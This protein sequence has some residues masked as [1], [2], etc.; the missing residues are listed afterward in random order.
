MPFEWTISN[1]QYYRT[2]YAPELYKLPFSDDFVF[3]NFLLFARNYR[4]IHTFPTFNNEVEISDDFYLE[5]KEISDGLTVAYKWQQNDPSM[6][7]NTCFMH[8]RNA[9]EDVN[10]R[11]ILTQFGCVFFTSL[12]E[13]PSRAQHW[14]RLPEHSASPD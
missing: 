8:W 10:H 13:E 7:D 11:V 12:D 2:F 1:A 14:Y 5:V 4:K 9:V 3:V 6:L